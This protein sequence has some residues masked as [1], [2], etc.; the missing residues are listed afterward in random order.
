MQLSPGD[1]VLI[2]GTTHESFRPFIAA[3][4]IT[5]VGHDGTAAR[6][7]RRHSIN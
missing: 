2:K 6:R 1:R 7:C 5:L 4:S 3:A